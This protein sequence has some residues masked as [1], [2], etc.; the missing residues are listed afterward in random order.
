MRAQS[1]KVN[2]RLDLPQA[3]EDSNTVNVDIYGGGH[4]AEGIF[5]AVRHPDRISIIIDV[6]SELRKLQQDFARC[7]IT[8]SCR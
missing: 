6:P 5:A 1:H 3:Y 2:R 8:L 4:G 7:Q